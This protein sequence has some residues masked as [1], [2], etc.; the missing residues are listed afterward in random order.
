VFNI[1]LF[2]RF[3]FSNIDIAKQE[4]IEGH[5]VTKIKCHNCGAEY[6]SV[7]YIDRGPTRLFE[8]NEP[9]KDKEKK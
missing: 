1:C 9:S 7:V 4:M 2:C 8:T 3:P 5:Q 6:K